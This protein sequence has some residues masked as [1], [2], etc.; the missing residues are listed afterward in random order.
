M[1]LFS[2]STPAPAA[3]P[4]TP[5]GAPAA[6][7]AAPARV[8]TGG[9]INLSKGQG[10]RLTKT[11]LVTATISWPP[12]TDYDVYALVLY[13]DGR[14]VTVSAF[15][16][17]DAPRDFSL[18]TEDGAVTHLGD[19]QRGGGAVATETVE[20][21]LGPDVAAVVPVAYSAQS[22]G[23]GSFR[24]YRVSMR[25]DNGAGEAVVV[26]APNASKSSTV[27]TC[28]PGIVLN[29]P[30][31]VRVEALELYSAPGSE[32]RPVIGPDG[33]VVMDAGPVNAYK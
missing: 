20:I 32:R 22:N 13:R 31:G 10:I 1:G 15:G 19:V 9:V 6:A 4:A 7:P 5:Q 18:A 25:I 16:T 2:R 27:Y 11:P 24:K 23:T 14:Q 29:G 28:V 17:K 26:D 21:R 8:P 33:Q 30:D 3:Q 12:A